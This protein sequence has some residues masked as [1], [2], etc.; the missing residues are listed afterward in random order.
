MA[1]KFLGLSTSD[2][3][4]R[5]TVIHPVTN[6]PLILTATGEECWIEAYPAQ[7]KR[8]SEVDRELTTKVLR[9]RV[10]RMSAKDIDE[11]VVAKLGMLT[12]GWKL[13]LLNGEPLDVECTPE[14][15]T[16]LYT[17]VRWLRDQVSAFVNDLGNFQPTPSG[18]S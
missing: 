13:A 12:T 15:A 7:S 10:Q 16:E 9:K 17:D 8:G 14:N 11:N 2:A 18:T 5:M 1:G 6:D 4:S 3:P